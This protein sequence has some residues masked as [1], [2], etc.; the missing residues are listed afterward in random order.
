ME[1][2]GEILKKMIKEKSLKRT[3]FLFVTS[4]GISLLLFVPSLRSYLV[5]SFSPTS[6]EVLSVLEMSVNERKVKILKV[7]RK[8]KLFVEIYGV[9]EN[10]NPVLIDRE[11]LTDIKDA[12]YKFGE[13]RSNLFLQDV[14]GEGLPEVIAPTYDKNMQAH[15]NIFKLEEATAFLTKI[16]KH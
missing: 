11:T 16:S 4:L 2:L 6:T 7:R 13:G 9:P 3:I 10:S 1:N 5:N 14:D 15:L 12:H 8:G